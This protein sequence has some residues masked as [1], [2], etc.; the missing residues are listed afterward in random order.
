MKKSITYIAV[1]ICCS[2][3]FLSCTFQDEINELEQL[4]KKKTEIVSADPDT[5]GDESPPPP[6][7]DPETGG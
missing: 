7:D 5:G 2:M 6:P 4:Q 3:L 1:S